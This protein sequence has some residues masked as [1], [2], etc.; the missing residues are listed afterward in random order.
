MLKKVI[1][2]EFL[3]DKRSSNRKMIVIL[4]FIFTI[5]SFLLTLLM[6]QN[7]EGRSNLV[8]AAY[9]WLP[10]IILPAMV[11]LLS[12]NILDEEKENNKIF[13]KTKNINTYHVL[14]A[15]NLVVFV[16]LLIMLLLFSFLIFLAGKFLGDNVSIFSLLE[17]SIGLVIGFLPIIIISFILK[18]HFK[19]LIVILGNFILG[20]IGAVAALSQ[21]W[22]VFPWCYGLK[23]MA[24]ILLINPN[25]TFLS[26]NSELANNFNIFMVSIMAFLVYILLLV[27]QIKL[28]K[29]SD[30]DD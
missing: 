23:L 17:G 8:A 10:L 2:T 11:T 21:W 20:I 16:Q 15:K 12:T 3:K 19:T 25:G 28:L 26:Q 5:L 18:L 30:N 9:N 4:P 27:L 7:P 13:Y 14:F 29:R 6:G 1:A 22:F 24:P